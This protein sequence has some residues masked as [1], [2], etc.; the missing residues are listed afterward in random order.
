M[1]GR[2]FISIKRSE[3]YQLIIATIHIVVV[4]P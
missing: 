2:E 1:V 3:E 4:G